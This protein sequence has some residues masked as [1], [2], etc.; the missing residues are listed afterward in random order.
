[1]V[2]IQDVPENTLRGTGNLLKP[3]QSRR[4]NVK[5]DGNKNYNNQ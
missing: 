4:T 5:K 3:N 1:M 2:R